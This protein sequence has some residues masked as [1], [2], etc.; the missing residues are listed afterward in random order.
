MG[1]ETPSNVAD[2]AQPRVGIWFVGARGGVA[3][4]ATLGLVALE[5]KQTDSV[6]LVSE[7]PKFAQLELVD[8]SALVVGGHEI[9]SVTLAESVERLHRES[10]LFDGELLAA[11]HDEFA[12]VDAR[13]RPG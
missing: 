12:T 7:L 2:M 4:V 1:P 6:G 9:R 5:R 10:R 8:W 11:C 3:S 13:I